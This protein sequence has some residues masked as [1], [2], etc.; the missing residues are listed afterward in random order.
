[1]QYQKVLLLQSASSFGLPLAGVE[2]DPVKREVYGLL[3]RPGK[4][5]PGNFFIMW[6][7]K[8]G[9]SYGATFGRTTNDITGLC[10]LLPDGE[11]KTVHDFRVDQTDRSESATPLDPSD[12]FRSIVH[13][14]PPASER[15]GK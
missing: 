5:L 3:G 7:G 2:I 15:N 13:A 8:G 10:K 4:Q 9:E 1:M 14:L 11:T 6:R 12:T